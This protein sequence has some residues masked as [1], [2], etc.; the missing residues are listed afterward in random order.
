MG[1]TQYPRDVGGEGRVSRRRRPFAP[2][3][4]RSRGVDFAVTHRRRR[5][6]G[7]SPLTRGRLQGED[8][9]ASALGLI[10]AHAGS[11]WPLLDR[12]RQ[13]RGSSPLTRGRRAGGLDLVPARR[14]IP[15][16]AGSTGQLPD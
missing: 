5:L 13:G 4:L 7:S 10:P 15:A 16:H 12:P 9:E 11:T 8:L 3:H 1:S 2:S 14:L 6:P